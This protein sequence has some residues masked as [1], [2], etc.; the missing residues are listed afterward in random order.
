MDYIYKKGIFGYAVAYVYTIEFQKR[1][2]PHMHCLIFLKEPHKLLTPEDID[3]CISAEF[4]DPETQP[5]LFETV[6]SHMVHGPCG[7]G[8]LKAACMVNRKCSKHYPK[9]WQEFTTMDGHGYPLYRRRN[10]GRTYEVR[11]KMVDNR[12]VVPYPPML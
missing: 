12:D 8:N 2:L 5:L 6:K 4:P 11:G 9:D 10:D 7:A 3:S 1:G